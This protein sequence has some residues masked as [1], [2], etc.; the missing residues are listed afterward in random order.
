MEMDL[1]KETAIVEAVL[2]LDSEPLNEEA[3]SK[4]AELSIDV[5]EVAIE[6]LK[7]KYSAENSGVELSKIT[8]GLGGLGGGFPF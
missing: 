2:F 3:I 5:V 4:I 1:N 8:G 7:E 6:N